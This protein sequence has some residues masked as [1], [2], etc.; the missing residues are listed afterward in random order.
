MRIVLILLV[1]FGAS[2]SS[3]ILEDS[4]KTLNNRIN[5]YETYLKKSITFSGYITKPYK[6]NGEAISGINAGFLP[7]VEMEACNGVSNKAKSQFKNAAILKW[8]GM[9]SVY[10]PVIVLVTES[11]SHGGFPDNK[12]IIGTAIALPVTGLVELILSVIIRKRAMNNYQYALRDKYQIS[13]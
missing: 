6:I 5:N 4:V 10:A 13:E 8:V 1:L 2:F 12:F 11:D 3:K 7:L 9:A